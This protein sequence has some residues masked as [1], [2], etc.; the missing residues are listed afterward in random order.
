MNEGRLVDLLAQTPL[1][2]DLDRE[3][4]RRLVEVGTVREV[5]R[6]EAVI[7]EGVRG[8]ALL[9]ILDG[10]VEV[11]KRH[12]D[13]DGEPLQLVTLGAGT[14]LGEVGLILRDAASAT[15]RTTRPSTLFVLERARFEEI[16]AERDGA[17]AT[18]ALALAKVLATRLQRMNQEAVELCDR[19]EEVL[20]Q[21]GTA[22][23]NARVAELQSFRQQLLSEWNF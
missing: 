8:S 16:L 12:D 22:K 1:A 23:G 5:G 11:L 3:A 21:A 15:V 2:R 20:A 17:A 7:E 6:G 14:I 13:F 4:V 19:Y 10:E 18:L 9:V